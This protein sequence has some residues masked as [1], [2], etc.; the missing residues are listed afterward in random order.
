MSADD[1]AAPAQLRNLSDDPTA[2]PGDQA[3]RDEGPWEGNPHANG[4]ASWLI[5][6]PDSWARS[7]LGDTLKWMGPETVAIEA[8][9]RL[10][11]RRLADG[12][13]RVHLTWIDGGDPQHRITLQP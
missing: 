12:S 11:A 7:I 9:L 4:A 5:H 8:P 10:R 13:I 1:P 3:V 6:T 2:G